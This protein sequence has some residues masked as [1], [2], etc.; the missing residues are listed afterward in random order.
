MKVSPAVRKAAAAHGRS[1][2]GMPG[3]LSSAASPMRER[4]PAGPWRQVSVA[5]LAYREAICQLTSQISE[6]SGGWD[7]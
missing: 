4:L 5:G 2:E 3:S 1:P 6:H 7:R